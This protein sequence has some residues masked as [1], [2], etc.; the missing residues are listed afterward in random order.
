M[1]GEHLDDSWFDGVCKVCGHAVEE[2]PY[3]YQDEFEADY[4]NRCTN[5]SC[6]EHFWHLV[7][8]QTGLEYYEHLS[9]EWADVRTDTQGK[10]VL[11]DS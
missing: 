9:G 2:T 10:V 6:K 11:G 7:D 3:G 4:A 8:D 5:E 1:K